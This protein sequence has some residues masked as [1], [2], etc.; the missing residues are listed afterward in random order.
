MDLQPNGLLSFSPIDDIEYYDKQSPSYD[1]PQYSP[2]IN[3]QQQTQYQHQQ[4]N[5]QLPAYDKKK[6]MKQLQNELDYQVQHEQLGA[7]VPTVSTPNTVGGGII[8]PTPLSMHYP[9]DINM[10]HSPAHPRKLMEGFSAALDGSSYNI[11]NG[12]DDVTGA[13]VG[14]GY[15]SEIWDRRRSVLKLMVITLVILLA[16]SL[17][18]TIYFYVCALIDRIK[19]R[20]K[21]NEVVIR[22]AYPLII[23]IAMWHLKA[24]VIGGSSA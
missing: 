4:P 7:S 1:T 19:H 3:Q 23:L 5:Q 6:M 14:G 2:E 8:A 13:A 16:I 15:F 11:T 10:N 9:S 24:Y 20:A 12:T 21:W 18:N 17:H 22:V